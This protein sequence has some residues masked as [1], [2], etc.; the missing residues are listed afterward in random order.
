MDSA[1]SASRFAAASGRKCLVALRSAS[2]PPR[3]TILSCRRRSSSSTTWRRTSPTWPSAWQAFSCTPACPG[4]PCMASITASTALQFDTASRHSTGPLATL[5]NTLQPPSCKLAWSGWARMALTTASKPPLSPM[6]CW[7]SL[8]QA[9]LCR[10]K[11]AAS[12]RTDDSTFGAI[13]PTT[14]FTPPTWAMQTLA[15]GS[16]ARF[17]STMQAL[18]RTPR[19]LGCPCKAAT[20]A[21]KPWWTSTSLL[22]WLSMDSCRNAQQAFSC[23][24]SVCGCVFSAS[25]TAATPPRLAMSTH[26]FSPYAATLPRMQHPL[27]WMFSLNGQLRIALMMARRLASLLSTSMQRPAPTS[28][29]H[30]IRSRST[31]S[32][33]RR[34]LP[35]SPR[36]A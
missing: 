2:A 3:A 28:S 4:W 6:S 16:A 27:V 10:R 13:E 8:V 36:L 1:S 34:P 15:S 30:R 12:W 7:Y 25:T 32:S 5:W 24:A 33:D 19:A 26:C 22:H 35:R 29:A 18:S 21:S 9:M 11:H 23:T 20:M 31:S 14:A 17:A